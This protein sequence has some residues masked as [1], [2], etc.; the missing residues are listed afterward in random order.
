MGVKEKR[1]KKKKK[2]QVFG[3]CNDNICETIPM[4]KAYMPSS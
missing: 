4:N 3:T 1:E 2:M